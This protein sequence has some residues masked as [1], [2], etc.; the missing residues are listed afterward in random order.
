MAVFDGIWLKH[1]VIFEKDGVGFFEL[2]QS[3]YDVQKKKN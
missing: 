2:H 3:E 1:V